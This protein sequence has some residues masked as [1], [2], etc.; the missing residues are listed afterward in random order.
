MYKHKGSLNHIISLKGAV[1]GSTASLLLAVSTP[2]VIAQEVNSALE[3]R[4]AT[5]NVEVIEVSGVRAS[6][7]NA[8][9]TKREASSIVDAISATD[10]DALPAL[11]FGEAL[12]A[13]P[14]IQ[15]DR[16]GEGRQSTISLRGLSG[17]FVKT[18]AFG[19]SFATPSR[20]FSPTGGTN[21]FAAFEAGVFDGVTVVKTPTADIQAGG[22]AGVVDQQLQQ[23]L[24]KV[25]GKYSVS[26]G[27]RYEELTGNTDKTLKFSAS[28][29]LIKD[30][31][32][33][34]FKF[35]G[36]EQ[37]FRRDLMQTAAHSDL[38]GTNRSG[39]PVSKT[40]D[41]YKTK[42][43][44][45]D[46][47]IIRG[48][49]DARNVTEFS[50]G[51]RISFTGN[52]EWKPSDELKLGA[53]VLYTERDLGDGTKEDVVVGT[54]L[55]HSN[56]DN[57]Q[58]SSQVEPDMDTA[59]FIYKHDDNG[60]PIYFVSNVHYTDGNYQYTN[61]KTTFL[62]SSKGLFLYADYAKG[63][64]AI[65]SK[66][67]YSESEN[68]FM[69]IGIDFIHN[70]HHSAEVNFT[71]EGGEGSLYPALATGINGQISTGQGNMADMI[72]TLSNWDSY[73]YDDLN[74][75][76]PST[77]SPTLTSIDESND[78]RRVQFRV[79]GRVD[80]PKRDMAAAEFNA[81]RYTEFGFGDL[82][83]ISSI[84]FGGRYSVESLVNDDNRVSISGLDTSNIEGALVHDNLL[85]VQ[86]TAYFNG[87]IPGTF[88]Q[89]TG[90]QTFDN[91]ATASQLQ[92][93]LADLS[94]VTETNP[95]ALENVYPSGFYERLDG[96]GFPNF[97]TNNF[98]V[99]QSITA[100]YFM[101]NLT[102]VLGGIEYTGNIG[103]RYENTTNDFVGPRVDNGQ[104]SEFE[105]E[106]EYDNFLP[107]VNLSLELTDDILLRTAHY[108]SLV[109][110]NLRSQNPS[111]SVNGG[112]NNVNISLPKAELNPYTANNYDLSLE[113]YNR[114]GSAV[115]IGLFKKV[116]TDLFA[117]D[118]PCPSFGE[119][120]YIDEE[121]GAL[122]GDNSDLEGNCLQVAEF[123]KPDG[124]VVNRSVNV[125]RHYN[126]DNEIKLNGVEFALQQKLDFLPYPWNGL[127]G[128]F[129]YTYIDQKGA[130]GDNKLYKVSPRSYNLITYWENDGISLRLAYN[131]RDSFDIQSSNSYFGIE[132]KKTKASGRLDFSGS[133]KVNER[134]NLYLKAYNLTDEQVYEYFG[135]DERALARIDYT[136]RIVS[137][138]VNYS[139]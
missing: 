82:I 138:S 113:W 77:T 11:D 43:G 55:H 136:G 135:D 115:S 34:A 16:S 24:S 116:I 104:I 23:A 90:W 33:V 38:V 45:S 48:V 75:S 12:Q 139:F 42:F 94:K 58:F 114:E 18:T 49:S 56:N 64:W 30:K 92:R 117:R 28:K 8:L 10:I 61:R 106:T 27:G 40:L 50:D 109:R 5:E 78:G 86:Q 52:I 20:T 67:S 35:S 91:D 39:V 88:G 36:S 29:H 7:E 95:V 59:P 127:G 2:S 126:A 74:W 137:V 128:V 134:L 41:E 73:N 15:L 9:N 81:E 54:G 71:P 6:L 72:V 131:W 120:P 105:Y 101:A 21:P 121:F 57:H 123:T 46:D 26:F 133:Y 62:E 65:D 118:N 103:A 47:A 44:L 69:N 89:G 122:Q 19:Q 85:S 76:A 87:K 60:N 66:V 93:N 79:N 4:K 25:D 98:T 80:N 132:N 83:N 124:E 31:L 70:Q 99:D 1:I 125:T 129:N 32:A 14:G 17:G 108:Q 37:T 63:D 68:Q 97:Y 110:P 107:S 100:A 119:Y 130:E 53:H 102:G 13:I 51:D 3:A 96:N 111:I 22:M 84:Q 112:D